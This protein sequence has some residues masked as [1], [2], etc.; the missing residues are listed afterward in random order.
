M[1]NRGIDLP[2]SSRRGKRSAAADADAA[3]PAGTESGPAQTRKTRPL[4]P[5]WSANTGSVPEYHGHG[6]TM[7]YRDSYSDVEDEDDDR[8]A[9]DPSDMD[10]DDDADDEPD[11]VPCP[12][13]RR[14][15]YEGAELCP[16]CRSYLSDE[17]APRRTPWWLIAGVAVCLAVVLLWVLT[18]SPG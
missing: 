11:T 4:D 6:I 1:E 10:S 12:Y 3:R 5:A 16:H 8:E 18:R 2:H 17:D 7:P 13:C 15:V 9:P 14:P